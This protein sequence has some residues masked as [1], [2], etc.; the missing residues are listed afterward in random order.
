MLI[1]WGQF[2]LVAA[3]IAWGGARVSRAADALAES[4][5]VGRVWMGA[6][7]VAAVTSLPEFV[8]G[9]VAVT[10]AGAPDLAVGDLFGSCVF[11]LTLLALVDAVGRGGSPYLKLDRAHL[12][13]AGFGL[14]MFAV[15]GLGLTT[16]A[17]HGTPL[18]ARLATPVLAAIY[19]IAARS[20]H[21]QTRPEAESPA[22]APSRANPRDVRNFV[23]GSLVVVAG[24][25]AMPFA[26]SHIAR[27]MQWEQS[28][29]GG[30]LVAASTSL[31]EISVTVHAA[32]MGAADL[33]VGNLLGSNLFNLLLLALDDLAWARGPLL[34]DVDP[35]NAVHLLTASAM[36]A[37][38]VIALTRRSPSPRHGPMT[39]ISWLLLLLYVCNAMLLYQREAPP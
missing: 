32:R 13:T 28:F 8:T 2:L 30:L 20:V 1:A 31:P 9:L 7:L 25:A 38:F 34:A 33:A 27:V 16:P 18:V 21:H 15:A 3:L 6:I 12:V 39:A 24:G 10:L 19:L 35:R 11:N 4:T 5:G 29:V 23:I 26:A 17:S 22:T 14:L 36:T 37:V